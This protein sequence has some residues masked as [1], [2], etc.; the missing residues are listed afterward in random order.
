M[1][2]SRYVNIFYALCG[3]IVFVIFDKALKW[4]WDSFDVL[5]DYALVSTHVTLTTILA[6]VLAIALTTYYYRKPGV[7]SYLSEVVLELKKVTWPD[8]EEVKRSTMIVIAF[9]II[10]SL[11]LYV[12]DLIWKNLT[13]LL[14]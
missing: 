11:Y 8:R 14:I 7:Y 12:F 4:L 6:L 3:A 2:V 9:T 1:D 10:L 5:T 13:D